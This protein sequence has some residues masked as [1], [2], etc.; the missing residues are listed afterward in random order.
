MSLLNTRT[1]EHAIQFMVN[2]RL[3]VVNIKPS[4]IFQSTGMTFPRR[5]NTDYAIKEDSIVYDL[6]AVTGLFFR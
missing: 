1:L 6:D 3:C 4:L 2:E 5:T